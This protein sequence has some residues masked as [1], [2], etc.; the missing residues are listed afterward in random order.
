MASLTF[1]ISRIEGHAQVQIEVED[2]EV[3]A[4]RFQAME[5]RGFS[6]FVVGTPAEQMPVVTPRIC[7]RLFHSASCGIRKSA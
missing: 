5:M 1:P 3:V 6:Q 7:G 4:A 2:G